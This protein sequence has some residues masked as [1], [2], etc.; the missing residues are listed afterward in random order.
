MVPRPKKRRIRKVD[1]FASVNGVRYLCEMLRQQCPTLIPK[2][3][4][5]LVS[6]LNAVRHLESYPA[7]T[8]KSG[9]PS[10]WPREDRLTVARELKAVLARETQGRISLA[11]FV[12]VYLRI[13]HF[14][15]DISAAL[16]A[17]QLTLQE[18]TI[19]ARV[20][21]DRL[22]ISVSQAKQ[23]RQHI[24]TAHLQT[25]GSQSSLRV[26]IQNL[27]GE[28]GK[29]ISGETMTSAVQKVDDL[30]EVD[31]DDTRHL[32]FEEIRNL[33]YALKEIEPEEVTETDLERFS[34]AADQVFN[35]IQAIRT[36]RK[37]QTLPR[38]F[39]L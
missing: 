30:L 11:S 21:A 2:S 39:S 32:F 12:G 36:R 31:P 37:R 26:R 17:N 6:L 5:Q 20:T 10:R 29:V 9:R 24:L 22:V 33:F 27:L 13:L 14:P 7:T 38:P 1:P 35:V 19:L 15:A 34:E 3:E 8:T 18:A 4:K 16:E 28:E 25:Q 23:M